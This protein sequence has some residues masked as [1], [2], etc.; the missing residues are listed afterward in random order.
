MDLSFT[1]EQE[2][3]RREARAWIAQ[4]MPPHIA[5]KAKQHAHFEPEETREWHRILAQKGWAALNWPKEYGGAGL[6]PTRRFILQEEL[7]MAGTPELS[8]FG[9]RM[10]GPLIVQ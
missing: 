5:Q 7:V 9:I 4:A 3:F 8:A 6:D 1:P 10:V 2:A